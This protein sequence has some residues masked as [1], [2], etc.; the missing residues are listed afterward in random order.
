MFFPLG[1]QRLTSHISSIAI[2]FRRPSTYLNNWSL[3]TARDFSFTNPY[4]NFAHH[5]SA[6]QIAQGFSLN[7][8]PEEG[9]FL[10]LIPDKLRVKS[11]NSDISDSQAIAY[12]PL[13]PL[14]T[15][16]IS[17]DVF[18]QDR[19]STNPPE[20]FQ[21]IATSASIVIESI[22]QQNKDHKFICIWMAAERLVEAGAVWGLYLLVTKKAK[23]A[24]SDGGMG[25]AKAMK[26]LYSCSTLLASFAE[27]WKVGSAYVDIWEAYLSFLWTVI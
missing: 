7:P 26:P 5:R 19:Q 21:I 22:A 8:R 12:L 17:S 4:D 13:H 6:R 24:E 3:P 9:Y 27:R 14:F 23:I 10:S 11:A 20:L 1:C 2:H 18:S 16:N 25:M 15:S